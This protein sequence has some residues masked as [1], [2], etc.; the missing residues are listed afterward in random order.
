MFDEFIDFLHMASLYELYSLNQSQGLTVVIEDGKITG[1]DY[2]S[3][4]EIQ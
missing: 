3:R 4:R 1:Y 2:E